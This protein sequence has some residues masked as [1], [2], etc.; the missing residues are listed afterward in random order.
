MNQRKSAFCALFCILLAFVL[1]VPQAVFATTITWTAKTP[2]AAART[3]AAAAVS[4][5]KIYVFGGND[6]GVKLASVER[7]DPAANTW[8][9]RADMPSARY[10]AAAVAVN[11]KIYLFG[12]ANTANQ[13]LNTVDVYDPA[14]NTWASAAA[15]PTAR[16]RLAAALGPDGKIYVVGGSTSSGLGL[17]GMTAVMEVYDPVAN[18]WSTAAPMK[19][20]RVGLAAAAS[21]GK[22][23]AFGGYGVTPGYSARYLLTVEAYDPATNTWAST[24]SMRT[25]R[26]GLAAV[27]TST[28]LIYLIGGKNESS[29][30]PSSNEEYNWSANTSSYTTGLPSGQRPEL[31]AVSMVNQGDIIYALGGGGISFPHANLD[32]GTLSDLPVVT[33]PPTATP[34]PPPASIQNLTA[35]AGCL[36]GHILLSWTAPGENGSQGSASSYIVR[37]SS[38]PIN[39]ESAWDAATPVAAG[40]PAPL[41]SGT[42]QSMTV[43][44][45]TS[46]QTVYFAIR[47]R[48]K[49]A[50]LA[51]LSNSPSALAP[52]G[53]AEKPWT[54]MVYAAADNNLDRYIYEDISSLELAAH[55]SCINL[56]VA[57]DGMPTTIRLITGLK[58]D[59]V[60]ASWA[61]Y[62]EGVD[63][64]AQGELNMGAPASLIAFTQWAKT[65]VP[66]THYALVIRD[67]GGGLGGMQEDDRSNDHLTIP[68]LDQALDTITNNGSAPLDLGFMDAC[69]MGMI[70]DAYQFRGR[71]GIYVASEDVTWSS[72]RSNSHHDYFYAVGPDT[73]AAQMA[74]MIVA[75]YADWMDAR[76]SGYRYTMSAGDM[77]QLDPLVGAV[78]TLA[79][80]LN[81]NWSTYSSQIQNARNHALRFW[82][83]DNMDL[84]DFSERIDANIADA[85][86]SAN[87]QAVMAA[88]DAYVL[89]ERHVAA[90]TGSHGVAIFFPSSSSSFYNAANYDFAAGAVWFGAAPERDAA[91]D[92]GALLTQYIDTFPGGPDVSQPPD[93][94]APQFPKEIFLPAIRR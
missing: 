66:A 33:P 60:M 80:S 1:L 93:P 47:A 61:A 89:S 68:E 70:E 22:I 2:M 41:Q 29:V 42:T 48:D 9:S 11:N 39:S 88:V 28:G 32:A 25:G 74:E 50:N 78:N 83:P 72:R 71:Y 13:I 38:Q 53:L 30:T 57:W 24:A 73:T 23:Y 86:I 3:W 52:A 67:H 81:A 49:A 35:S 8:D 21:G 14:T 84:Y 31:A 18:S 55:N 94:L 44:G 59:P 10:G 76:L 7:Y 16:C 62:S 45:L 27:T 87:A 54:I 75:G 5:G 15:M 20:T 4:G 51:E 34:D 56:V 91:G 46:G 19:T 77:S 58:F 12:G 79:A 36:V 40:I 82:Y 43:S 85:A 92:W 6:N 37:Y 69:L 64:W 17:S 63:K 90:F 65:N 26:Y